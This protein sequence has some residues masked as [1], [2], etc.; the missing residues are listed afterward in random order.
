MAWSTPTADDV[1]SEFTPSEL[2]TISTILGKSPFDNTAPLSAVL[3][4]VV[5]EMRG[6]INA[7]NYTLDADSTTIPKGL[8][9]DAIAISRWRFLISAPQ[10]KQ[11]QTDER[12]EL[13]TAAMSKL[14]LVSEQKFA[15]EDPLPIADVTSSTWNSENKLI[16]RTHPVPYPG[17]QFTPQTGT[18]A[19]P[20]APPDIGS[21]P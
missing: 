1:L 6:Y 7:G 13:Y 2:A 4:R 8:F 11:L 9:N 10:F 12:K 5:D 15:V 18:Y 17:A 3:S 21:V 20:D 16:M 14:T 19:N